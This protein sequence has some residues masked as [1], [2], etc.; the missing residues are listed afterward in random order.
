MWNTVKAFVKYTKHLPRI[1]VTAVLFSSMA[2]SARLEYPERI[3]VGTF[4]LVVLILWV[5]LCV[6]IKYVDPKLE[7][8]Q[9]KQAELQE[10]LAAEKAQRE[11]AE[12]KA[13]AAEAAANALRDAAR[14]KQDD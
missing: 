9:A 2:N 10:K 3:I 13:I 1:I 8:A 4:F 11:D 6:C 12:R 5:S 7:E 14:G